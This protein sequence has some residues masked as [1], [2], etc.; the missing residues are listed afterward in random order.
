MD[1]SMPPT[2]EELKAAEQRMNDAGA[3]LIAYIQQ[4][5]EQGT[6]REIHDRLNH[7]LETATNRFLD[8]IA[9]SRP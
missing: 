3:A 6:N 8:L 1:K 9:Q 2:I 4:S 7:E 5:V